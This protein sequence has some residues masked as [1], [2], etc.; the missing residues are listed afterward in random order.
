[1]GSRGRRV[2]Q[3]RE[4]VGLSRLALAKRVGTHLST[5]RAAAR[6]SS[7]TIS[8]HDGRNSGHARSYRA[9]R[10]HSACRSPGPVIVQSGCFGGLQLTLASASEQQS[11]ARRSMGSE[12]LS[13]QLAFNRM[14]ATVVT[15]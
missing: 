11:A 1:M 7:W 6:L 2:G 8:E 4:H 5:G 9:K 3:T 15:V 10:K 14:A 12:P 13:S